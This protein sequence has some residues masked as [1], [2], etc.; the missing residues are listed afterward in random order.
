[1]KAPDIRVDI[2]ELRLVGFVGRDNDRI[3]NAVHRELERLLTMP[4]NRRRLLH[5]RA[6]ATFDGGTIEMSAKADADVIG[7]QVA[8][9]A[10]GAF[11][12]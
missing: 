6:V 4:D 8:R 3:A 5:S 2:E 10:F 1:V 11:D 7:T 9:A 12:R